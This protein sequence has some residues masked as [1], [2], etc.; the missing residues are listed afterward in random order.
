N[1]LKVNLD[2]Q[3][4][5]NDTLVKQN[6]NLAKKVAI[7]ELIK[8]SDF[9]VTTYKD[10]RNEKYKESDKASRVDMFKVS[11][12]LNKNLLAPKK[13]LKLNIVITKPDGNNINDKGTFTSEG[14]SIKYTEEN[15]I[16]YNK[17]EEPVLFIIKRNYDK[18]LEKGLYITH[19][20][21][22]GKKI[23][24]IETYLR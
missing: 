18:K 8:A 4:T 13:T 17:K 16:E 10:R 23:K 19:F 2:H 20:Y 5:F 1:E 15:T 24:S 9:S 6:L 12:L 7:G 3:S 21:L 11:F 14:Q 22:D